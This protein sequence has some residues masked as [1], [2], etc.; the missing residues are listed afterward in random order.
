MSLTNQFEAAYTHIIRPAL[1]E[2]A[3]G[4]PAGSAL[5]LCDSGGSAHITLE[6]ILDLEATRLS[7]FAPLDGEPSCSVALEKAD[8]RAGQLKRDRR[9]VVRADS[10]G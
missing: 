8:G 5:H 10:R 1:L 4:L 9:L 7:V 3:D 2:A 6:A